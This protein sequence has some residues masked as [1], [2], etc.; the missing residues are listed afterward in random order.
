VAS[1]AHGPSFLPLPF[2]P[3]TVVVFLSS[4]SFYPNRQNPR[5]A[6]RDPPSA[7]APR[8]EDPA[9]RQRLRAPS[10]APALPSALTRRRNHRLC[11]LAHPPSAA[12]PREEDLPSVRGLERHPQH[13]HRLPHQA[14][15]RR[16]C[17]RSRT[18]IRSKSRRPRPPPPPVVRAANP[19]QAADHAVPS[20]L[21]G[22]CGHPRLAASTL[23]DGL[24]WIHSPS[25]P[26]LSLKPKC[27]RSQTTVEA[28][29]D[30][31]WR[32]TGIAVASSSATTP[33]PRSPTSTTPPPTRSLRP[34]QRLPDPCPRPRS[35]L[36]HLWG[37]VGRHFPC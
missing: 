19:W 18:R 1:P 2:L 23:S 26:H 29:K 13:P 22:D 14:A 30:K 25:S 21:Q 17:R 15:S 9:L 10:P 4:F 32:K 35:L 28:L 11:P 36:A 34:L 37:L 3:S 31:L 8:E 24:D 33:A 16:S 6:A 12:A 7:A 5:L 27:L 20:D